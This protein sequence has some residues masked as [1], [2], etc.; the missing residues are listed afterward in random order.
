M[1]GICLIRQSI[2]PLDLLV[3]REAETLYQAGYET[4]VICLKRL[5]EESQLEEQ[6]N[7]VYVHHLPLKRL[8]TN[9]IRYVFDYLSFAFLAFIKVSRLHLK[10]R[11]DVIQVNNM[12]DLLVF[13]ALLPKLLGAKVV[14]MMYEPT[15]ELWEDKHKSPPPKLIKIVEQLSLRFVDHTFTVTQQL[16]NAY[17]SRGAKPEKI[18]VVLNAPD[19]KFLEIQAVHNITPEK[20][21]GFTLICHGAIEERYGQDTILDAIALIK[22]HI[23]NLRVRILGKGTYVDKMIEQRKQLC[24]EDCVDYLGYVPLEQMIQEILVADVGIVAQ[25]SSPYSNLVHTGKMY[26]YIALGKPVIASRLKAVEAYFGENAFVYFD[27]ANPESLANGILFLHQHPE[28]LQVLARN[29]KELYSEYRWE[30]QKE[31]Y[32]SAY[33][34]I[35]QSRA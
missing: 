27:P 18:Q 7:G 12:P 8:K 16:K 20:P 4:H 5:D 34:Q 23:P 21:N 17:V 9:K 25:K 1:T 35:I 31:I 29:A 28:R 11:F 26:E 6:I 13:A 10:K 30:K 33:R 14:S 15:P 22:P 24:L 2:Y 19:E 32:L 3:R